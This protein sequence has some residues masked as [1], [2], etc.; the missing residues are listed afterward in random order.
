MAALALAAHY[1][2]THEKLT[3]APVLDAGLKKLEDALRLRHKSPQR[4]RWWLEEK[5]EHLR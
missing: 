3:Y 5:N 1:H 2:L 4:S